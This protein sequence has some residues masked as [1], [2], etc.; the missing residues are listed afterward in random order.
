MIRF[1][2]DLD[3]AAVHLREALDQRQA[4][5]RAAHVARAAAVHL[6]ELLEDQVLVVAADADAAV[7]HLDAD[8]AARQA[9]LGR[10]R[11]ADPERHLAAYSSFIISRDTL[12][13]A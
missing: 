4:E 9:G 11:G 1:R 12:R 2:L 5:A 6:A 3:P 8:G 10:R 13:T 7:D